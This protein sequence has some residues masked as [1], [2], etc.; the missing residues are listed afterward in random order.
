MHALPPPPALPRRGLLAAVLGWV[1][2]RPAQAQSP[3]ALAAAMRQAEA[4]RDAALRGG[5]QPYGIGTFGQL[6]VKGGFDFD[7]RGHLRTGTLGDQFRA[8]GK[9]ARS[10]VRVKGEGFY[11]PEA[12]DSRG[13][14]G[15]D[16]QLRGYLAGRRA[17]VRGAGFSQHRLDEVDLVGVPR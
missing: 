13:F 16:G 7:S 12:W 14:G 1:A 9:P 10:G 5:D 2:L 8:D 3:D 11:Y 15:V 4:L 6:G 17:I